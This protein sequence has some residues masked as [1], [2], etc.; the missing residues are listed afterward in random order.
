M[1][2][3][4]ELDAMEARH[5]ATSTGD[6]KVSGGRLYYYHMGEWL[7]IRSED[8][9]D[10]IVR[11]HNDDVP[12][13]LAEV[14]RL[15]SLLCRA[16]NERVLFELHNKKLIDIARGLADIKPIDYDGYSADC[17]TCRKRW[18]D[19][20]SDHEDDCPWRMAREYV[21]ANKDEPA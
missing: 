1:L 11:A 17:A 18:S 2:T 20:P 21:K 7:F 12:A 14:R 5:E 16:N 10:F 15:Q 9:L 6:W 3:N 13:L 4:D 19:N 8:D